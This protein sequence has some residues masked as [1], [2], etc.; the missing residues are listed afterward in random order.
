[1]A[2][3]AVSKSAAADGFLV[4]LGGPVDTAAL[5]LACTA[6]GEL[7]L[8]TSNLKVRRRRCVSP[9]LRPA[10]RVQVLLP[11]VSAK[12]STSTTK[13]IPRHVA[14]IAATRAWRL[15]AR[16]AAF[17]LDS[18]K[19]WSL[20]TSPPSP[21]SR[22]RRRRSSAALVQ[23]YRRLLVASRRLPSPL[24]ASCRLSSPGRLSSLPMVQSGLQ[25]SPCSP[26]SLPSPPSPP[27]AALTPPSPLS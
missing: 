19:C 24:I 1:M 23:L 3:Q 15:P 26:P 9:A 8:T 27:S 18:I 22:P 13:Y 25:S 14:A 11:R 21:P 7:G 12:P 17:D 10:H 20:A 2:C 5:V 6:R 16:A 4:E